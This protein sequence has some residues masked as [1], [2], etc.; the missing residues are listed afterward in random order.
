MRFLAF[1][2]PVFAVLAVAMVAVVAW[3]ATGDH[4]V[5][6]LPASADDV[7]T[8]A[9]TAAV[10]SRVQPGQSV[11]QSFTTRPAPGTARTFPEIYT[12]RETT[13]GITVVGSAAISERAFTSAKATI[14]R[15]FG[16]NDL[17]KPLAE[18]GAYVIIAEPGQGVL[19]LPE[20]A[21]LE[22]DFGSEFFT[23]VC[24]IADRADYP[25]ATV[26]ELDLIGQRTGPCSGLNILFHELGHLVQSWSLPPPDY[27]DVKSF[28]QEALTA[29]KYRDLYAATNPNE[30]FAE[31]TQAYF[32]STDPRGRQDRAWLRRY[33]PKLYTLLAALYG[34]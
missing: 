17:A 5:P 26:N 21:C 15:M 8:E 10:Q 6:S 16:G 28:Y 20:F 27:F 9:P 25:V 19:D 30:Y 7:A 14:E 34:D 2:L 29:G 13:L 3:A 11:C 12:R 24:G 22:K 4:A 23:H 1:L 18:Q 32:L 31:G 33:D